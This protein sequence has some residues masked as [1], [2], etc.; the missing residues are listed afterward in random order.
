VIPGQPGA[1]ERVRDGRR[2]VPHEQ[3]TLQHQGHPL[4]QAAGAQLRVLGQYE[5]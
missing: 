5:F 1:A 4:D 2:R 3:R